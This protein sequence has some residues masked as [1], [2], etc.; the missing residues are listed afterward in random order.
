MSTFLSDAPVL[1]SDLRKLDTRLTS[2]T[3]VQVDNAVAALVDSAPE[4]LDTLNELALAL[5]D[6]ANFATTVTNSL[7]AKADAFTVGTGLAMTSGVLTADVTQ[8][9]VD[10]KH[11]AITASS[12][13]DA[14]LV[15]TGV[16]SNSELACLDGCTSSIQS[17]F[18]GKMD[19][20]TTGD[21][22]SFTSNIL[23][24]EATQAKLDLKHD[25]ISSTNRLDASLVGNGSVSNSEFQH[26]NSV[27]SN[28]QQQINGCQPTITAGNGLA[29][30]GVT[31]NADVSTAD[32]SAKQDLIS[33]SNRLSAS[34]VGD[35]SVSNAEL[36][37][38]NGASA[39]LQTQI[40]GRQATI[41]AGDG[42]SF[43]GSTL[44]AEV[45]QSELNGKEDTITG[46]VSGLV[47]SNLA[48][49]MA[50]KTIG[51]GKI[52]ATS[53]ISTIELEFLDGCASNLQNQLDALKPQ[54]LRV[55]A[56]NKVV[57]AN[58]WS[59][60]AWP[61]SGETMRTSG[62]TAMTHSTPNNSV[63]IYIDRTGIYRINT[64]TRVTF[65][66]RHILRI[67][68]NGSQIGTPDGRP[69]DI[70]MDTGRTVTGTVCIYATDSQ[71]IQV[72]VYFSSQNETADFYMDIEWVGEKA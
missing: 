31:L 40:N 43:S 64:V 25:T 24:A 30:S 58:T 56:H 68:L 50:L 70:D 52:V 71:Y 57:N 36:A 65:N 10:N 67:L 39:N 63:K 18:G 4:A 35:G 13:L 53:T 9:E 17:Q 59:T 27:S 34:L 60:I 46:A 41:T 62:L 45:T 72:Q 3:G 49:N 15:G 47:S 12:R 23:T 38:V 54:W 22:L 11:P 48:A 51:S 29:F 21:G 55:V 2:A 8:G 1:A 19:S 7:A 37:Y 20:F 26:L 32:L 42:L 69:Y 16:V 66:V 6:D 44:N 28:I 5:G 14:T 33:A 61:H